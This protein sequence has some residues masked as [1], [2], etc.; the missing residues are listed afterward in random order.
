VIKRLLPRLPAANLV[1]VDDVWIGE[2][3][4]ALD[5][6]PRITAGKLGSMF[7]EVRPLAAYLDRQRI[8]PQPRGGQTM[9][10]AK[11]ASRAQLLLS[12]A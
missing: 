5:S 4:H 9:F 7:D 2:P 3:P 1:L 11:R 12:R 6:Y 10:T 8:E